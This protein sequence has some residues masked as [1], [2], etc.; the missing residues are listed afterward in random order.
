[1]QRFWNERWAPIKDDGGRII[2]IT[3]A[4]EEI[5]ERKRAEAALRAANEQLREADRRKDEFLGMLSHELRN[6]LAPIRNSVYVLRHA[7]PGGDQA[8]RAR[9]VI[10]RQTEHLARL[11][12]DLL[13]VTRIAKGMIE[14]RRRRADLRELVRHAAYDFEPAMEARGIAFRAVLPEVKIWTNADATRIAQIIGNLLHNAAKFTRRGDEVTLSLTPVDGQAEIR[15]RDTG[16]GINPE[17][18]PRVFDAFAQGERTLAR[19]NGGLGLGLA[20][21]KEIAELHGGTVRAESGG[22]GRGAEFVVRLPLIPDPVEE[23][24]GEGR[25]VRGIGGRRVLVVDDNADSAESLAEI[26]AMLGNRV[27]VAYDGP[28]AVE[29]ARENRPDVVLCDVGLPGMS[30]YDVAKALRAA[31]Y[32]MQL[33]ALSGYAQPEDVRSAVEAG[34]DG[35]LAKPARIEDIERLLA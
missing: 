32:P 10:E 7:D 31:G 24:A 15:V 17:F 3:V 23:P 5:S 12:D 19:S 1:V 2:G 6:P 8:R 27:D 34:F 11:V 18:L 22:T 9:D 26:L 4:A 16:A 20:L 28:S 33:F 14:L 30:G 29:K 21:V 13:D 35:H 25:P